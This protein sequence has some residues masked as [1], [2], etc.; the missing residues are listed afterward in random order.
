V[1]QA[2]TEDEIVLGGHINSTSYNIRAEVTSGT[3]KGKVPTLLDD[4]ISWNDG[5][6]SSNYRFEEKI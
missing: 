2:I 5:T 3:S 1:V 6:G 4:K